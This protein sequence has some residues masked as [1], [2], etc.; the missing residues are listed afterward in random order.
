MALSPRPSS[1][2]VTNRSPEQRALGFTE[3]L[4]RLAPEYRTWLLNDVRPL[5]SS[6]LLYLTTGAQFS[7]KTRELK[8]RIFGPMV[9]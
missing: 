2:V 9:N 6:F 4:A 7:A 5:L 1:L 8:T 3:L